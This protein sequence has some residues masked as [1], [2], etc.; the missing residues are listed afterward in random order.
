[1]GERRVEGRQAGRRTKRL[2]VILEVDPAAN[3]CDSAFPLLRV[4]GHD[5]AAVVVVLGDA[6]G[7]HLVGEGSEREG[8]REE[9]EKNWTICIP[10]PTS[11]ISHTCSRS[12]M[13]SSWSIS[14]STGKPWQSQ[15]KRRTT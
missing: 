12:L 15:P 1:M 4:A 11:L 10:I 6:H 9:G 8:E 7:E 5:G 2:V 13:P 3:A 14:N